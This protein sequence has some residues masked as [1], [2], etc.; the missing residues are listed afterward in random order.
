MDIPALDPVIA[1]LHLVL[2]PEGLL[3]FSIT[4]PCFWPNYYG[5][6]HESWYRYDQELIIESPFRITARPD[7]PL[8]STH[9]HRPLQTYLAA[10]RCGGFII[11]KL[12]EPMPSAAVEAQYPAPWG[13]PRYLVCRCRRAVAPCSSST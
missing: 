4:H 6:D 3:I 5:Y 8:P 7:C 9:I 2:R 12:R 13:A 11:D 10:L 1:A